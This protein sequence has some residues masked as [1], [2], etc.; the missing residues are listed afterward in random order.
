MSTTIVISFYP[1]I[2]NPLE[3]RF[4]GVAAAFLQ[5]CSGVLAAFNVQNIQPDLIQGSTMFL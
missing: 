2:G 1:L 5:H 3:Q 4:C